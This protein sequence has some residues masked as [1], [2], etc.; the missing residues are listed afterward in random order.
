MWKNLNGPASPV[1]LVPRRQNPKVR[2]IGT[3]RLPIAG[4]YRPVARLFCFPDG[5]QLWHVRLWEYYRAV[6]HVVSTPVLLTYARANG[7]RSLAR[8]IERLA[9]RHREE[10]GARA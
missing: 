2:C 7:L 5:R 1:E 10:G 3:V 9:R 8:E 4:P 6:P